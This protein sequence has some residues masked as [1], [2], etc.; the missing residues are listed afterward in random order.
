MHRRSISMG[1]VTVLLSTLAFLS[2]AE[3]KP[4]KD[5]YV[6][7]GDIKMHYLEA[8]T[9]DRS[10]V[11]IPGLTMAAEVWKEQIPYFTARG[12]HVFAI[13]PR[14]QGLT[15]KTDGGNTYLQ[16]AADL[17]AFLKT[18][19]IEHAVLVGW[20]AAVSALLD[21]VSSPDTMRPDNLVF[22]DGA[23][24]GHQEAD[25]PGGRTIQQMRTVLL[26]YEED[27]AKATTEF[28]RGMF[29][30]K[31][32]ELAYTEIENSCMKTPTGTAL[33]LL[34]DLYTG[35]RRVALMRVSVPTLLLFTAETRQVG[36]Y[37]QSKI[38]R[39]K[40]EVIEDAGHA[41]FLDKPQTFNQLVE[42]FLGPQ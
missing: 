6:S 26:S 25:Y 37:M 11:F 13:D 21:Y 17:H 33:A 7:L 38:K 39:A 31:Q 41:M 10:I 9:G 12:F 14:S 8:G 36:E 16:Q 4:W 15:T 28:V 22:V 40:L 27:R 5:M 3:K 18:L 30:T 19:K 42:S 23:P 20:S 32:P 29:K 1:V 24:M 2:G 34:F 35:D